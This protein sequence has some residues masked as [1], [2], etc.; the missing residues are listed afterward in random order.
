M[1]FLDENK[2][3]IFDQFDQKIGVAGTVIV[4]PPP[5]SFHFFAFLA[6]SSYLHVEVPKSDLRFSVHSPIERCTCTV[7]VCMYKYLKSKGR[8]KL[9]ILL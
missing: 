6:S 4:P 5:P 9:D 3:A 8:P 1:L 2:K 7:P